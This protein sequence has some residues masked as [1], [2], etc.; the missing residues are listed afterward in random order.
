MTKSNPKAA[1]PKSQTSIPVAERLQS[2]ADHFKELRRRL[3]LIAFAV[4]GGGAITYNFHDQVTDWLLVPAGNQQFIFTTPGGGFDFLL[5]LCLYG[6]LLASIPVMVYQVLRFLQPL[7]KR[8]AL[9]FVRWSGVA[10]ALLAAAG[11]A[12]GYF[13][14]LPAAMHFLLQGFSNDRIAALITIQSYLTF[15]LVYLVGCA[16]LFQI[17]L[18]LVLINRITR[19]KPRILFGKQR[20]FIVGALVAGAVIN[21]SP[22]IQ[23]QLMLSI[24]M[25]AMYQIG[26]VLIWLINRRQ[27]TKTIAM[28]SAY[29]LQ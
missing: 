13:V 16:L 24:P 11:I 10:A 5:R 8:D 27:H 4:V 25:I 1:K 21:P 7:I 17:P 15:V 2:F 18:L 14:G 26:I 22:N 20:W 23:D 12:F 28:Q 29:E 9:R 19:L 3:L 6:G